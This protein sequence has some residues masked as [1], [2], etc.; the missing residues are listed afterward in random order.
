MQNKTEF[1]LFGTTPCRQYDEDGVEGVTSNEGTL[2]VFEHGKTKA[3]DLLHEYTG[4]DAFQ[5]ITQEEHTQL[6]PLFNQPIHQ[7][8]NL[9]EEKNTEVVIDGTTYTLTSNF[10]LVEW[11][12]R[13]ITPLELLFCELMAIKFD[14]NR[15]ESTEEAEKFVK[16]NIQIVEELIVLAYN[17]LYPNDPFMNN[18]MIWEAVDVAVSNNLQ[19]RKSI[20]M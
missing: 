20:T 19:V 18:D 6:C 17:I 13:N 4:W 1:Y 10:N 14:T 15:I 3:I 16:E 11:C 2:F 8:M 7:P 12:E 9:E 5:I